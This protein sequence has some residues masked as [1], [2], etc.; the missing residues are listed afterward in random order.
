[1]A[2]GL[3]FVQP[4]SQPLQRHVGVG[5][6]QTNLL[7][8][9]TQPPAVPSQKGWSPVRLVARPQARRVLTRAEGAKA[10]ATPQT[11]LADAVLVGI[12]LGIC[13]LMRPWIGRESSSWA[14]ITVVVISGL[15]ANLGPGALPQVWTKSVQRLIGTAA[16]SAAAG[17]F[18]ATWTGMVAWGAGLAFVRPFVPSQTYTLLIAAL[19][20]AVVGLTA[21]SYEAVLRRGWLRI[22]G[23]AVGEVAVLVGPVMLWLC[24]ATVR[25]LQ[26]P[27]VP[28]KA[29]VFSAVLDSGD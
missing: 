24:L 2:L 12:A 28:A 26:S 29:L 8:S 6:Q 9:T 14:A 22:L 16:G 7:P 10:A 20:Y 15:Q 19:T 23:V 18:G 11:A 5:L 25:K 3:G 17:L 4:M 27:K 13:A 1:M 21:S